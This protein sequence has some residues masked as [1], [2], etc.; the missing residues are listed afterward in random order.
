MEQLRAAQRRQASRAR[1]QQHSS[2][3]RSRRLASYEHHGAG[4]VGHCAAAQEI[5]AVTE[6]SLRAAART[7]RMCA[8][9]AE[10][11]CFS[12]EYPTA[13][14]SMS[15]SADSLRLNPALSLTALSAD[16]NV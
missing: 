2:D 1:H 4:R 10:L 15:P 16:L 12:V 14:S 13:E 5:S 3:Q 11:L 8:R 9:F 6:A 7:K